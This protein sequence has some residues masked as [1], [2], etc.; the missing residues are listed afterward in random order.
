MLPSIYDLGIDKLSAKDKLRL[1]G[2]IWD[3]MDPPDRVEL[4]D[5]HWAEIEDRLADADADPDDGL[6]LE[7]TMALLRAKK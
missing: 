3:S 2:E 4:S 1:I 5:A 7:E 6:S